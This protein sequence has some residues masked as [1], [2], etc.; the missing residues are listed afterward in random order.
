MKAGQRIITVD[1]GIKGTVE[2]VS[3]NLLIIAD[4]GRRLVF[5]ESEV[6]AI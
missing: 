6:I 3:R 5:H 4:D 2:Q 1:F